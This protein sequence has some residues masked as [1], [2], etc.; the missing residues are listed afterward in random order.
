MALPDFATVNNALSTGGSLVE[1]AECHGVLCGILCTTGSTDMQGWVGHLFASRDESVDISAEALKI[2]HDVHQGTLAGINHTTLD[3][4]L[5]LPED[6]Y[7]LDDRM[8]ALS[9][10][11][12]GFSLGLSMGGLQESM[13]GNEDV[14]EFIQDVQYIAEACIKPEQDSEEN[15]EQSLVEIEEYLRMGV[16]FLNE[17]LQPDPTPPTIH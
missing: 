13:L 5:L 14:R 6:E 8:L 1:A 3:F 12:S 11:C 7:S 4:S 16:L 9:D 10:W 15:T 2:L 17:E